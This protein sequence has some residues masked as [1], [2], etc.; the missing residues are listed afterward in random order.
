M[1]LLLVLLLGVVQ[2]AGSRRIGWRIL[3]VGRVWELGHAVIVA[4]DEP[5]IVSCG[6]FTEELERPG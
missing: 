5:S 2:R 3:R 1:R 6:R 4:D